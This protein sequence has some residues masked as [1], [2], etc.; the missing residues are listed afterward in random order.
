VKSFLFLP[1][2]LA[3]NLQ[4]NG[5]NIHS[6][7]TEDYSSAFSSLFSIEEA[8]FNRGII[9][10]PY[11]LINGRVTGLGMATQGND[12]NGEFLLRVRGLSTFQRNTGPLLVIDGFVVDDLLLVDPNDIASVSLL[13]DAASSS[14]YGVQ[15]GNGVLMM[16]TKTADDEHAIVSFKSELGIDQAIKKLDVLSPTDY[17]QYPNANNM[18]SSVN[19]IDAITQTGISAVNSLAFSKH[20]ES[21]TIRG[22]MNSR[23]AEGTLRGTGFEQ[24]N[25][26][27]NFQQKAL[28]NRLVLQAYLASTTRKSDYG[29]RQAIKYGYSTN[30]TMSIHDV[31]LPQYGGYSQVNYFDNFNPVAI[32][33]QNENSGKEIAS[34]VGL[35][36]Q[37]RFEGMM[38]G[39]GLKF[40]YQLL[41]DK[42]LNDK[43]FSR[44]SYYVG[45][46]RNGLASRSAIDRKL[47]QISSDITYQKNFNAIG[48][49][50]SS[51]YQYQEHK[52]SDAFVEGGDFLTDAFAYNNMEAAQD[53]QNGTGIISTSASSYKVINWTT[54]ASVVI[55]K[56]YFVHAA[57]TYSGSTRLG[58]NNKWGFF[59]SVM[60]GV[61]WEEGLFMFDYLKLRASWGKA[62][63][64]PERSNMSG[65][66]MGTGQPIYYNGVY[67][68]GYNIYRDANPDLRWEEKTEINI[69]TDFTL[70]NGHIRGSI[71]WFTSDVADMISPVIIP[72]PPSLSGQTFGN[73]GRLQNRGV[74]LYVDVSVK[75]TAQF[76]WDMSFN[77]SRVVTRVESLSGNG[78]SIGQNGEMN[79]GV[80]T[81]AGGGCSSHGI[82][83]IQ[84]GAKLGQIQGPI[85]SG[86]ITD[87]LPQHRDLNGDG[88]YCDCGD[89]FAILGNALPNFGFG[90]GHHLAYKN[91]EIHLL[92]RGAMGHHKINAYRI[93]QEGTGVIPTYNLVETSHFNSALM[94]THLS[95]SYVE[96]A[97]FVKLD[98]VSLLYHFPTPLKLSLSL[99]IQNLFTLTKYSGTDPE[100]AYGAADS[101]GQTNAPGDTS[102]LVSG[103]ELRGNYLPSRIF[104]LGI[105]LDL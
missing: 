85:F 60:A 100:V 80:L 29:F 19:W 23:I 49:D 32:I 12:P 76:S 78:Y 21:F 34:S 36:G 90:F 70:L 68:P 24:L 38:K 61:Q 93:F 59:P 22:S 97:S 65:S 55:N 75:K 64:M 1:L 56:L 58:V 63:N 3:F 43:Y 18:G 57:G 28:R 42:F 86:S 83:K 89:D 96:K 95:S 101:K 91:L 5:Q 92:F 98:N 35:N 8:N 33:E 66:L 37:Y 74:E 45:L 26:R 39:L 79:I 7:S 52:T 16:T 73:L 82:N 10:S 27:I 13:K 72:S 51:G 41:S 46:S 81:D 77:L 104:S 6:D 87:G 50:V 40:S 69:G 67:I 47:H 15:G 103:L 44:R 84:E 25:F 102:P 17:K 54:R 4:S 88:F 48:I 11:Q 14:Q 31:N 30:P 94:H 99:T 53:F 2:L 9:H 62:G 20:Y 105:T 71:D